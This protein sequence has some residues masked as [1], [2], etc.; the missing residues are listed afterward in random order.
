MLILLTKAK[1]SNESE[2]REPDHKPCDPSHN[3]DPDK[4]K[5]H[6]NQQASAMTEEGLSSILSGFN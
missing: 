4:R 3:D 5:D 2:Y 1:D 6:R